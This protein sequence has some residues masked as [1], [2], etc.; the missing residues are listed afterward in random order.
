MKRKIG[1][2]KPS[3]LWA[4][5]QVFGPWYIFIGLIFLVVVSLFWRKRCFY[6]YFIMLEAMRHL[7]W[8]NCIHGRDD[9]CAQRLQQP[10]S[11]GHRQKLLSEQSMDIRRWCRLTSNALRYGCSSGILRMLSYGNEHSSRCF[12]LSIQKV[13][14]SIASIVFDHISG[15]NCESFGQ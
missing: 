10:N 5:L 12:T 8:S 6:L 1:K 2:G 14:A 3:L 13:I 11:V 7:G 4:V 15:T 9:R